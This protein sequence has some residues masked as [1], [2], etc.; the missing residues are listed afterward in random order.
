MTMKNKKVIGIVLIVIIILIGILIPTVIMP[1]IENS[2]TYQS[3]MDC[4]DEKKYVEAYMLFNELG[5]YKD[6]M[7]R[8]EILLQ[9]HPAI[10][11]NFADVLDI[12]D[13]GK[14]KNEK[15]SWIVVER[16]NGKVLLLSEKIIER[17]YSYNDSGDGTTWENCSLRQWL[18]NDFYKSAFTEAEKNSI[19][20]TSLSN[21]NN[22]TYGTNGGNETEDKVFVFSKSEYDVFEPILGDNIVTNGTSYADNI[23]SYVTEYSGLM[24]QQQ[25][26]LA[27]SICANS[28]YLRTPGETSKDVMYA[29]RYGVNE[30][31]TSVENL[32]Y[33][34][35]GIRPAILVD[36]N[37]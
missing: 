36:L 2:K 24:A 19:V 25:A 17:K 35:F 7:Q 8:A 31:G 15:I 11:L 4:L 37:A 28:W 5:E 14:Y 1:S 26:Q 23:Y 18:N 20:L 32:S 29:S 33:C 30:K 34:G 12:V 21:P 13:Y 22:L 10:V 6:S 27:I 16:N 3:A 9:E